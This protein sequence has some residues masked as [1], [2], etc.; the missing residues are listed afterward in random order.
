ML[1]GSV[2]MM[3]SVF[4][5]PLGL[6]DYFGSILLLVGVVCMFLFSRRLKRRAK[7][8]TASMPGGASPASKRAKAFKL[9]IIIT[10]VACATF[11]FTAPYLMSPTPPFSELVVISVVSFILCAGVVTFA[12]RRQP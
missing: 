9:G 2:S 5:K 12:S 6:P 10:A 7:S 3:A 8:Q 11:P 1:A 4:H